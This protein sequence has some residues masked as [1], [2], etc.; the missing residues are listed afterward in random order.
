MTQFCK[1]YIEYL[2]NFICWF[3]HPHIIEI[4]YSTNTDILFRPT[5]QVKERIGLLH[6]NNW[7]ED[8]KKV[9]S[10]MD[11][12]VPRNYPND[13]YNLYTPARSCPLSSYEELKECCPLLFDYLL[14]VV[15]N[16]DKDTFLFLLNWISVMF[17]YG[18]TYK[19]LVF[20]GKR[21]TGKSVFTILSRM[22]MGNDKYWQKIDQLTQITD[23]VN[24]QSEINLLTTLEDVVANGADFH[25]AQQVLK[26]KITEKTQTI[27]KMHCN[28]YTGTSNSNC[29]ININYEHPVMIHDDN[30]RFTATRFSNCHIND[31]K[32]Y[33]NLI[34]SIEENIESIRGYFTTSDCNQDLEY[35]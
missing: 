32:Y 11:F 25:L 23:Q 18:K 30:R 3:N 1:E 4:R 8:D 7:N 26:T 21:G 2:N 14:N 28:G 29:I 31:T 22:M 12:I 17:Q 24:A 5:S 19:C 34:K 16:N 6:F 13:V 33:G 27:R 15:C 9:Y 35:L 20:V 10:K